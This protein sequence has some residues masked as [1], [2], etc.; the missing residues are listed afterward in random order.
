M[1]QGMNVEKRLRRMLDKQESLVSALQSLAETHS[2]DGES[3]RAKV[4]L[5][6]WVSSLEAL[7]DAREAL[8]DLVET[9]YY[10]AL[11]EAEERARARPR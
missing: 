5:M 1:A 2:G 6:T 8:D 3:E 9:V 7:E 4:I 10:A 11:V